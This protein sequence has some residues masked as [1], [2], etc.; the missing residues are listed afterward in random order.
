MTGGYTGIV[1]RL[2]DASRLTRSAFALGAAAVGCMAFASCSRLG[3]KDPK[4]ARDCVGF[5][6]E[7]YREADTDP[8][9]VRPPGA[10]PRLQP[11]VYWAGPRLGA[12]R[13]NFVNESTDA[14]VGDSEEDDQRFPSYVVSYQVPEDGCM[15]DML[16]GYEPRPENWHAGR[17]RTIWTLPLRSAFAQQALVGPGGGLQG[18]AYRTADGELARVAID[19]GEGTVGLIVSDRL[20][21]LATPDDVRFVEVIRRLRAI[22]R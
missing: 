1:R 21:I 15:T 6:R 8:D 11:I 3:L 18:R 22:R 14:S 2:L 16:P 12:R 13:A 10:R 19:Y 7:A 20:V 9:V 5:L 4:A 17:E